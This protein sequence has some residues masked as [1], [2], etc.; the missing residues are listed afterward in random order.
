MKV[1]RREKRILGV[2]NKSQCLIF[3]CS[4][5][6]SQQKIKKFKY[7]SQELQRNFLEEL[8]CKLKLNSL[9]DW[10]KVNKKTIHENGGESLLSYYY[11]NNLKK[12]LISLYP[13]HN[14]NFKVEKMKGY[15]KCNS[16]D[17][18]QSIDNQIE[19]MEELHQKF[20]LKSMEEWKKITKSKIR[21]NGGKKL[22]ENFQ[23]SKEKILISLFPNFPWNFHLNFTEKEI[24]L[25]NRKKIEKIFC[26]LKLNSLNDWTKISRRK[27]IE[28][29]GKKVLIYYS[30]DLHQMLRSIY[31]DHQ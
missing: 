26:K 10:T 17:Y 5:T 25:E 27:L 22:L 8:F 15:I 9:D 21:Q 11:A 20:G 12:M 24:L 16:D 18:F 13:T 3:S 28:N 7:N 4:F 29:G 23:F 30:N 14:W 31:P 2:K 1:L 19:F 6:T